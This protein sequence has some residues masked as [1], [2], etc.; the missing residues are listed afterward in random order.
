MEQETITW[1]GVKETAAEHGVILSE[2]D[3][4]R[5]FEEIWGQIHARFEEMAEEL[6]EKE[7]RF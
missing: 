6:A 4:E 2:S 3:R 7:A 5:E 1:E